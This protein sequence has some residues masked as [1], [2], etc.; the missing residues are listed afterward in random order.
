MKN[1]VFVYGT[2]L[3]PEVRRALLGREPVTVRAE[4]RGYGR[5]AIRASGFEPFPVIVAEADGRVNGL[6]ISDMDQGEMDCLDCFEN[7]AG[8]LYEKLVLSV[9][10]EARETHGV[11]TYAAGPRLLDSIAEPWDPASF[12]QHA[13]ARFMR[14]CFGV[15]T[16]NE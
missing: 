12:R 1:P 5:Y 11:I 2:L 15:V 13:L 10:S 9:F 7:V 6:L 3:F 4:L 8:G 16:K 14:R